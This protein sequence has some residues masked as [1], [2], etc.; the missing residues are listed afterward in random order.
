MKGLRL[1]AEDFIRKPIYADV[2]IHRVM[3]SLKS[4]SKSIGAIALSDMAKELEQSAKDANI[5]NVKKGTKAFM[6]KYIDLGRK[7]KNIVL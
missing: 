3:H 5:E 1:G 6:E 4:M 7:I 2:L